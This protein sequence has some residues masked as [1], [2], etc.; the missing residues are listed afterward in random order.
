MQEEDT[1]AGGAGCIAEEQVQ[2]ENNIAAAVGRN[3]VPVS[4]G[5]TIPG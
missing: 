1:D 3:D 5:E 2:A 4:L